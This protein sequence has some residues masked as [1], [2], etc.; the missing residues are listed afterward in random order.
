M[1]GLELD[2]TC[3]VHSF[4][5]LIRRKVFSVIKQQPNCPVIPHL[6]NGII[7]ANHSAI[8]YVPANRYFSRG[9]DLFTVQCRHNIVDFLQN[10]HKRHHIAYGV[11]FVDS[12]LHSYSAPVTAVKWTVSCYIRPRYNG[13]RLYYAYSIPRLLMTV[14]R[15]VPGHQ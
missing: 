14:R 8:H 5:L 7:P 13:T 15:K 6:F 3:N 12:N 9:K 10:C 4:T 11:F 1:Y 2:Y